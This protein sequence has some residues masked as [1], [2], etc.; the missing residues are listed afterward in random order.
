MEPT[1][2]PGDAVW[3]TPLSDGARESLDRGDVVIYDCEN[4]EGTGTCVSRVVAIG[5]D[6]VAIVD[7]ALTL[8][9]VPADEP[10]LADGEI[11]RPRSGYRFGEVPHGTVVVLGDN[12][13]SSMDSR[14]F[15]PVDVERVRFRVNL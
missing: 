13:Q 6:R 3:A 10:Y 14:Y 15:G 8:N 1:L 7:D 12:R 5:G 2:S 11:T 9:G 4:R